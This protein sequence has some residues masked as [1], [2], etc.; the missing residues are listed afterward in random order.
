MYLHDSMHDFKD[1]VAKT[2]SHLGR[3][4]SFIVK[5]YF[6]VTILKEIT[7]INPDLVFKG[8]TCLSKCYD[9][10]DRFSEDVDLG[11]R[12]EHASEGMRKGIKAAVQASASKLGLNI[13]NISDTKSR[14]EYNRYELPL[15]S[16]VGTQ[17]PNSLI[18]ET[19]VMTPASPANI[20][21]IQSFIGE[22][23]SSKGFNGVVREYAL[24]PFNVNANSLERTFCDKVFALCD[25]YLLGNIPPRQSRHIYDLRKLC[26]NV[27]VDDAL[28]ELM[29]AVR[30]QREGRYHCPSADADICIPKILKEIIASASYET[31]YEHLTMPLLYEEIS[32]S[33]AIES[34]DLI[35]GKMEASVHLPPQH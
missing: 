2:A 21:P 6:A 32:Y 23:C 29:D 1:L 27:I 31:D 33:Q 26:D 14:R 17:E 22:Y 3:T 34:L 30:S 4:G 10:I 8:G 12:G 18:L 16:P 15:P 5:D 25:Y 19:A 7:A 24:Q 35:A 13:S 11:V 9:I 28:F 20:R